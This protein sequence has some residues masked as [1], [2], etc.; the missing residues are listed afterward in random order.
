MNLKGNILL[1]SPIPPP[2]GGMA[3]W[4]VKYSEF[5]EKNNIY[6][7]VVN[8]ALIGKRAENISIFKRSIYNEVVRTYRIFS[9]LKKKLKDEKIAIAHLN[10]SCSMYGIIRDY[11]LIR[12]IKAKRTDI[13]VVFECHC[14]L[15]Y[16]LNSNFKK[17]IFK[18]I[19]KYVDCVLTLNSKSLSLAKSLTDKPNYLS[20]NFIDKNWIVENKIVNAE[21][22]RILYVGHVQKFKGS[23]ELI[24]AAKKCSD[25]EFMLIGPIDSEITKD[26][27]PSNVKLVGKKSPR[28][29]KELLLT[30]DIFVFPSYTEGFSIALLEAMAAGLP[31][32]ATN[33]GA[34]LDMIEKKGGIIVRS[35]NSQD[36]VEAINQLR[37]E[38]VRMKM[39][40]WNIRK[41]RETYTVEHV[42]GELIDLYE[43]LIDYR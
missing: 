26:Y 19:S 13:K 32:I 39:S 40:N 29:V 12:Y 25:I 38:E 2:E 10:S 35:Q 1:V 9:D 36:I 37:S 15:E 3:T 31:I 42:M 41:V 28:E 7:N 27:I 14:N 34:N 11:L 21:L 5:C 8:T 18:K 4:T 17:T 30:A 22:K 33:V 20:N 6:L 24:E 43:M 23:R 16:E